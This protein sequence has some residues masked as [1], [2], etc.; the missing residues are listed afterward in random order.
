M[1]NIVYIGMPGAGKSTL[2]VLTAK[3]LGMNFT[4]TDLLVQQKEGR[5]LQEIIDQSGTKAFLE[6]EQKCIYEA[7][8][9]NCVVATGGSAVYGEKAMKVLKENGVIVY[10]KISYQEMIKRIQNITTRGIVLEQGQTLKDVYEKRTPMYEQYADLVVE[11]DGKNI[12][13]LLGNVI[14]RLKQNGYSFLHL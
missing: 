6:I 9:E 8:F 4:D 10:L 5:L 1:N 7:R 12:E 11:C 2:G 13:E 14:H 3:T